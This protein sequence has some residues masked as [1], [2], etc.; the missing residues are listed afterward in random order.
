[1][2]GEIMM[3]A[4]GLSMFK[5]KGGGSSPGNGKTGGNEGGFFSGGL[6]GAVGRKITDSAVKGAT[7]QGGGSIGKAAFE[8]SLSKG[9]GFAN[10]I[11]SSIATGNIGN[12]GSITGATAETAFNSYMGYKGT[13]TASTFSN[14]EI[15][16]G[17]MMGTET[18][19]ANPGGIEFGMY[20]AE[21]Y[22]APDGTHT[23]ETAVDGSKWYKQYAEDTVEKTPY[24]AP[25]GSVAYHTAIVQKLPKIPQR[26]DRV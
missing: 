13:A 14:V 6:V 19:A 2:L 16:G 3:A 9:G 11:I 26:K 15:G 21:Q 24:T 25:N 8:S 1:M 7:G 4:K 12:M 17:R 10:N 20:N 22:M 18:N 5:N 23:I